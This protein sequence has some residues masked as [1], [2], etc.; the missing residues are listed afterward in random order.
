M[1]TVNGQQFPYDEQGLVEAAQAES[2]GAAQDPKAQM[3]AGAQAKKQGQQPQG[4]QPQGQ[5]PQQGGDDGSAKFNEIM[6]QAQQLLYSDEISKALI[7]LGNTSKDKARGFADMI[8]HAVI[9]IDEKNNGELPE[10]MILPLTE[11]VVDMLAEIVAEGTGKPL[12]EEGIMKASSM[13]IGQLL[14]HYGVDEQAL[15]G[16]LKQYDGEEMNAQ[17]NRISAGFGG[18]AVVK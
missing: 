6:D 10:D 16:S 14:D 11:K 13:A 5:Q 1:P 18:K 15:E 2:R 3:L 7:E 12:P 4:Q 9:Q 8:T 17:I